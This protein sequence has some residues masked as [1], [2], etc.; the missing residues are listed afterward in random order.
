ME[1]LQD[2]PALTILIC[3]QAPDVKFKRLLLRHTL[4]L[5]L[6]YAR[7]ERCDAQRTPHDD[8][9]GDQAA[10][11]PWI[12]ISA[13]RLGC[14]WEL[15]RWVPGLCM[16][17]TQQAGH[18][19]GAG[20]PQQAGTETLQQ[21]CNRSWLDKK[22]CASGKGATQIL[23]WKLNFRMILFIKRHCWTVPST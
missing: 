23:R 1:G 12:W 3:L 18:T 15:Q 16:W 11:R 19:E 13:G 6:D 21:T 20:R 4:M 10:M 8:S 7:R 2:L 5:W 14:R 17:P 9:I 22:P